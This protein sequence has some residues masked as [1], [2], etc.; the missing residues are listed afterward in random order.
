MM[1]NNLKQALDMVHAIFKRDYGVD[2]SVHISIYGNIDYRNDIGDKEMESIISN[3]AKS[4]DSKAAHGF[5]SDDT[6]WSKVE[7]NCARIVGFYSPESAKKEET[8][9]NH[10]QVGAAAGLCGNGG[11][12]VQIQA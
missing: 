3:V 9:D 11:Q 12:R 2:I 4:I 8:N 7:N 5:E 10:Q 6:G 1:K